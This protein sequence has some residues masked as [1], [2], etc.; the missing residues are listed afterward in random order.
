MNK[1]LLLD[2][3]TTGLSAIDQPIEVAMCLYEVNDDGQLLRL[4]DSYVG[5]RCPSVPINPRAQKIHKISIAELVGL[6]FDYKRINKLVDAADLIVAHNARFD[7]RMLKTLVPNISQKKWRCTLDQWPWPIS[8]GRSLASAAFA[9]GVRNLNAHS[10]LADV[11]TLA[12]CLFLP[13]ADGDFVCNLIGS[14][15][16]SVKSE[17]SNNTTNLD[18]AMSAEAQNSC[19]T[20]LNIIGAVI[21][22]QYLHDSEIEFIAKWLEKSPV[23]AINWPGNIIVE[24]LQ[25][26]LRDGVITDEERTSL[27]LTLNS[28]L[29]GNLKKASEVLKSSPLDLDLIDAIEFKETTFLLT[30]DFLLGTKEACTSEIETRGGTVANSMTKKV[31]IVVLGA[32]GSEQW[33]HGNFGTKVAKALEYKSTGLDVQITSEEIFVKYL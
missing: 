14:P 20:L 29:N 30:G 18:H 22:D 28:I 24:Q 23:A 31:N 9:C 16:Y 25:Q 5:R 10:A 19:S 27:V 2:T 1:L 8:S 33:K 4:I 15:N 26:V 17:V 12:D 32:L 13:S 7:Y 3:E 21:A 11:Q 6:D